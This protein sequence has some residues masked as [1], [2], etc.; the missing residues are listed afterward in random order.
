MKAPGPKNDSDLGTFCFNEE[1]VDHLR[2]ALPKGGRLAQMAKALKAAAHPA[3]LSI[4]QI[5]SIHEGC[6]CDVA[7]TLKMP[8]STASQH[9]RKLREAG[10]LDARQDGKMMIHSI[11]ETPLAR[12]VIAGLAVD[13]KDDR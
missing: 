6:V 8:V 2:S 10:L 7:H 9:L 4:L 1:K 12:T 3:R 13:E 5:L 11:V